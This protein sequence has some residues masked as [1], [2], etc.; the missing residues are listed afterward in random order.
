MTTRINLGI[1]FRFKPSYMDVRVATWTQIDGKHT[2][3]D[4]MKIFEDGLIPAHLN[5]KAGTKGE[6]LIAV[7]ADYSYWTF[8]TSWTGKAKPEYFSGK[9]LCSCAW[10]YACTAEGELEIGDHT[11][12][13]S[14]IADEL[15][16][17]ID[18]SVQSNAKP[19]AGIDPY[20]KII[21]RVYYSGHGAGQGPGVSVGPFSVAPPTGSPGAPPSTQGVGNGLL[22][23]LHVVGAQKPEKPKP[24]FKM[25]APELLK[26]TYYFEH[27]RAKDFRNNKDPKNKLEALN[28]WAD[29]VKKES[30]YLYWAMTQKDPLKRVPINVVGFASPP[31]E[32]GENDEY[33]AARAQ[34]V[35]ERL[36][37]N[38]GKGTVTVITKSFGNRFAKTID[39][40]KPS[41]RD[42]VYLKDRRV[43]IV[44]DE[45]EVRQGIER[46]LKDG[47]TTQ[48]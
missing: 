12:K 4:E 8:E 35:T 29:Q 7:D 47:G 21:V 33:A 3:V 37:H 17:K 42:A 41:Q 46:L 6:I 11:A 1:G 5:V 44:L 13:P 15:Q 10:R 9:L 20:V 28:G 32:Y 24:T 36:E 31:G 48:P 40:V 14:A 22:V 25:P 45:S 30:P 23:S 2:R 19:K 18:D 27:E 43:E 34:Y 16:F 26:R 38:F 39:G